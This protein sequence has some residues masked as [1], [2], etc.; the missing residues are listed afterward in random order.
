MTRRVRHRARPN[1]PRERLP[2]A[3]DGHDYGQH[4]EN[5]WRKPLPLAQDRFVDDRLWLRSAGDNLLVRQRSL[6]SPGELRGILPIGD[7]NLDRVVGSGTCVVFFEPFSKMMS[8][9]ADYCIVLRVELG[10][11]AEHIESDAVFRDVTGQPIEPLVAQ[12]LEQAREL[13]RA[14]KDFG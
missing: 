5:Q 11:P 14:L 6:D 10:I 1:Q 2:E 9:D 12:V 8:V 7:D 13:W 3:R 4:R